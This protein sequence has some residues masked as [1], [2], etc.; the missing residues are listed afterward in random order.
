MSD[1]T[2]QARRDFLRDAAPRYI[3]W[4]EPD[5]AARDEQKL[6]AAIMDRG[7]EKDTVAMLDLFP[8]ERIG[9]V[10]RSAIIGQFS[11]R[12]W[13]FW[14]RMLYSDLTGT[15]VPPPLPDQRFL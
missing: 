6:L 11:S 8:P 1:R 2:S 14:H 13:S 4:M 12:S 7:D 10:L 15:Y 9:E 3:W 5:E